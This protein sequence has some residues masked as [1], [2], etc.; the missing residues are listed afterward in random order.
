MCEKYADDEFMLGKLAAHIAQLPAAMD[1]SNQARD[2]KE[3]RKKTLLTA[4]DDFIEQF[5]NES[6]QYYYNANVE[7]FFVYNADA[8][9]N[10]S[11]INEDD[12]LHPILTKISCNRELMPWKYKIKN[13]VLRRIKDRDLLSS[14]PESQTI[15]RTLN[16]L[17]PSLF[18]TRDC[19]KYF[20]T[21]LGDVILK[22][23]VLISDSAISDSAISDSAISDSA[24]SDSAISDSAISDSAISNPIYIATPKSRQ[25]IKGLSQ[26]CVTLF[27]T[28]LL[29]AFKFKFYEYAFSECRL[30]DM[31]DVAMDAFS[32]PFKNRLIDIFCVAAHYS[33]RY[34]NAE[35][36]LNTQCKDTVTHQRVLYLKHHAEDQL[37]AKFVATCTEPS[38][39][40]NMSIS[41]KNM[42]YLWKV[43]IEEERIPNVFFAHALRARLM[44]HLPNYSETTDS[45]L[46]LTSKHL[47]LVA[48]FKDF[49]THAIVLTQN[50]EPDDACELEIDEFTMLFKQHHHQQLLQ[51]TQPS[52]Q[53]QSH[54][55]TDATFLGLI[56][57]FYPDVVIEND[58][59]LMHVSCAMWDKRGDVLAAI[60]E[61][62]DSATMQPTSY[63]AY[64]LYCQQQRLKCKNNAA[65]GQHHLIVSKKYFEK[66]YN[67]NK[68]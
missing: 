25:F 12:I 9:C 3:H 39:L 60:Q 21:V 30:L 48:R 31:N 6:P 20:L 36:F 37:I 47:P 38:P 2:D 57:H 4:S 34:D 28:S 10:Y 66:I 7:L 45:F 62:S 16:M 64:E 33:Q 46:Q 1:A 61:C 32:P 55:H 19:A 41:W 13:Q 56:R 23:T 50:D 17:C 54:N 5:L 18:R 14:I 35:A 40:S 68:L 15:Q 22:K 58:K 27:G 44:Q 52:P 53:L 11:V 63:K 43:F 67:E 65:A 29:S 59:H 42:M 51:M 8:D 24:I 26:E 49:W